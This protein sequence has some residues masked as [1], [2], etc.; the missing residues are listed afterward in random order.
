MIFREREDRRTI[1]REMEKNCQGEGRQEEIFQGDGERMSGRGRTG[2]GLSGR[3]ITI[4]REREDRRTIV[5]EREDR[6]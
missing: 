2:R 6:K 4:V 3:W 1:V 5:R